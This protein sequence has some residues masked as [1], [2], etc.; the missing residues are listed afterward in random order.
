MV[1]Y[2]TQYTLIHDIIYTQYSDTID[3][4]YTQYS[5]TIKQLSS[6]PRLELKL[7]LIHDSAIN[8]IN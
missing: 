8:A 4:I 6:T 5:D 2:V 7:L 1:A 3:I